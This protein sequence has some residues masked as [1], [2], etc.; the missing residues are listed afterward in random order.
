MSSCECEVVS[1]RTAESAN[2]KIFWQKSDAI[3]SEE[4]VDEEEGSD[5]EVDVYNDDDD[6]DDV[7]GA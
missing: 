1:C 4:E 5:E 2:S 7:P 6:D 3:I